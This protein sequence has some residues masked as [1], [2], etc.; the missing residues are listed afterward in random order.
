VTT[1]ITKYPLLIEPLIKTA[2]ERPEEQQRL[3]NCLHLVKS[4]LVNVNGQVAEKERGQRLLEIYNRMDARSH[5][6]NEGKKFKKSDILS[7]N[8]KLLFEGVGN[9]LSPAL[10]HHTSGGKGNRSPAPSLLVNILVLSDVVIFLQENSQKYN[11]VTPEGK[12][13]VVPVHTL[14]ARE[15]PGSDNKALYLIST[16]DTEPEMYEIQVVQPRDRHDWIAGVRRAVDLS[17]GSGPGEDG[18]FES[19]AERA[20][21]QLEAKYMKMRQLTSEL[22][23]KDMELARLLEDKM[24][25]LGEMLDELGVEQPLDSSQA[26][27]LHLV[28]EKEEGSVTK[29][30]LLQQVA[31][32]A[33]LA[34][35]LY[36]SNLGRSVSSVGEHQSET[37]E[38]PS[39]PR[40]AET[41]GGFDNGA[42]AAPT[43]G[44]GT[45]KTGDSNK[46]KRDNTVGASS[47]LEQ[48]GVPPP[49][50]SLST[51]LLALDKSEQTVAVHMTHYLNN[52]MCMVSEH[53]TSLQSIKVELSECKERATLGYGRYKHNQQ[54]EE[55]RNLQEQLTA[56]RRSWEMHRDDMNRDMNDKQEQMNKMQAALEQER[57]DVEQQRDKLYR[58]LEALQ[59]QGFEIG[60]NMTVIGPH[61]LQ[62][63]NNEPAFVMEVRKAVSP[64]GQENR[65]MTTSQS[66]S[67]VVSDRKPSHLP[68]QVSNSNIKKLSESRSSNTHLTSITNETKAEKGEPVKQQI[69]LNLAKLSLAGPKAKDKKSSS[70]LV[71][72]PSISAPIIT[73]NHPPNIASQFQQHQQQHHSQQQMLP[74][75]LS[76]NDRKNSSP[77]AGYQKLSSNSFAAAEERVSRSHVRENE[78]H[79][80]HSRTGSSPASMI[81]R[82][83]SN[84][85]PKNS[86]TGRNGSPD[87]SENNK[88][89]K[90]IQK[91]NYAD[92]G[93]E[94]FFF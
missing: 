54:L 53:F 15:K 6:T 84:T 18:M 71:E 16:S 52:I 67:G 51:P 8:R 65:K 11:F 63:T 74:F 5:V 26:K 34:S 60:T 89:L 32:A 9:L 92:T 20:R 70:K 33:K 76:E 28:Q 49:P 80:S 79:V 77:K 48:L 40:R 59:A 82:P 78:P 46:T 27:Y 25:I 42:V 69:P 24:R 56:E 61:N 57:K 68:P 72:R 10:V 19:E 47:P 22:R 50:A 66:S 45:P 86:G 90:E 75:K 93:E 1:R 43:S 85:L 30:E 14:I 17:A 21:K 83:L 2:K 4:I 58:K 39:L 55:L 38:S 44:S 23:G 35:S 12:S 36:S 64:P 41:F 37:Y 87:K 7:E 91:V 29:E 3:R 73:N 13:G 88:P 31:E 62:Q 81:G 94:V